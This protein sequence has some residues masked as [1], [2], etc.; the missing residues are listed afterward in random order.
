M[1][2]EKRPIW[3]ESAS[4]APQGSSEEEPQ[5]EEDSLATLGAEIEAM[6]EEDD[7]ILDNLEDKSPIVKLAIVAAALYLLSSGFGKK[8]DSKG[9]MESV[10]AMLMGD[11]GNA[12]DSPE[13]KEA[14]DAIQ[15]FQLIIT[16]LESQNALPK[17]VIQ[18]D[19]WDVRALERDYNITTP[20]QLMD[21]L[22]EKKPLEISGETMSLSKYLRKL[23]EA[24]K[25]EE[26]EEVA[27][28][29]VEEEAGE[30][31]E[32]EKPNSPFA[33]APNRKIN[34]GGNDF[35]EFELTS[36]ES[37]MIDGNK[38]VIGGHK[39][40]IEV[41]TFIRAVDVQFDWI[42]P[43]SNGGYKFQISTVIGDKKEVV[44]LDQD[45]AVRLIRTL[46]GNGSRNE[47]TYSVPHK[48]EQKTFK[49]TRLS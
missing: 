43:T 17:S 5:Q 18:V 21:F 19:E 40:K 29:T 39:Y 14:Q 23:E 49:F 4:A 26:V 42:E 20:D 33:R 35:A 3:K 45:K 24:V 15:A 11:E 27:E 8:G 1:L 30:P 25:E 10:M 38:V 47:F 46:A 41:E 37:V 32:E 48:G 31:E 28:E 22:K 13:S 9:A 34:M 44:T 16:T 6:A 36:G 2:F 12:E 7:G